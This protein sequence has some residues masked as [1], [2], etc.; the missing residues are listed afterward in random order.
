MSTSDQ[1]YQPAAPLISPK[2]HP[3]GKRRDWYPY[4]AGFTE[5]FAEGL[6]A[7]HLSDSTL[8]LDP[9]SGSGTTGAVCAR[10]GIP[11]IGVDINPALTVVARARLTPN[12][13]DESLLC[14]GRRILQVA[15]DVHPKP[16]DED[17]LRRWMRKDA[18]GRIRAVQ[19][20]IHSLVAQEVPLP[21]SNNIAAVVDQL[22]ALSCFFYSALFATTRDLLGRF[23]TSNP[24]WH[25]S[26]AS[27]RE[28]IATPWTQIAS[29][30]LQRVQYLQDRLRLSKGSYETNA[31]TI[32]TGNATSLPFPPAL[33]DGVLTSPPYATRIDYVVGS[34][35]ELAVLGLDEDL[36]MSLRL[37]TTGSPV[38]ASDQS[39]RSECLIVSECARRLVRDI[40]DHPSKGSRRYYMP[41]M[42]RYL[43][44][45]QGSLSEIARTVIPR[46]AVCL[47]LQDSYYKALHIDLQRIVEE[48]LGEFGRP[49]IE[50]HDYPVASLR[51]QMNP[52]ARLHLSTRA[53]SES[54]LIFS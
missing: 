30:Y 7:E 1:V 50:R 22:S 32:L 42:H 46:R 37:A 54:I 8:V 12:P 31:A 2:Q 18:A 10:L 13:G 20:A 9:W 19:R 17:P 23:R 28:K 53:N 41:W 29:D 34:L 25:K 36:L 43:S 27:Y 39:L 33:F 26:P 47:V 44:G 24:M 14:L 15:Q 16:D 38:I 35:P 48:T 40:G 45:L 11:S 5:E 4:Y 21:V 51:S 52:R 49:L 3:R 6:L